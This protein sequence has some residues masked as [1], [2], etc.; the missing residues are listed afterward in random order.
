MSGREMDPPKSALIARDLI[1]KI[2]RWDP[3]VADGVPI[4]DGADR[5][6]ERVPGG[7]LDPSQGTLWAAATSQVSYAC[8]AKSDPMSAARTASCAD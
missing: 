6:R 4:C 1:P 7:A 2:N 3:D 8:L 5:R